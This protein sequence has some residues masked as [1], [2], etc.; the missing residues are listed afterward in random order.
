MCEEIFTS[1]YGFKKV[2]N[3]EALTKT[4]SLYYNEP[5]NVHF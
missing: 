2:D 3:Q 4:A 1:G 5:D